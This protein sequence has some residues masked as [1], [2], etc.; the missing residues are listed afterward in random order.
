[1]F[2]LISMAFT[3]IFLLLGLLLGVLNPHSVQF[4]LYLL[5][6]DFPLGLALAIA[7]VVGM[8]MG[9]LLIKMQ[10]TQLKWR[11]KKQTRLNQKQADE[12]VHAKKRL[13]QELRSGNVDNSANV[14]RLPFNSRSIN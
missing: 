1:M 2:K 7:L 6:F 5:H 11:L 12:L 13:A 14:T 3:L 9:A 4:D 8:L 10:V